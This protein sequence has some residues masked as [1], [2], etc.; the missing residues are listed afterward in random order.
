MNWRILTFVTIVHLLTLMVLGVGWPTMH[1]P[2]RKAKVLRVQTVKLR[3]P[4]PKVSKPKTVAAKPKPKKKAPP[5]KKKPKK[6]AKKTPKKKA[7][8][9]KR[10]PEDMRERKLLEELRE[11]LAKIEKSQK[12][13]KAKPVP[14]SKPRA[15]E[16]QA[17]KYEQELVVRLRLMLRLPEYGD[18]KVRLTLQ[19][20][21]SIAKVE[22]LKTKSQKNE[23]YVAQTLPGMRFPSFGKNYRNEKQHSFILTLTGM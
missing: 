19:R 17:S 13:Y 4:P 16:P 11:S 20:D 7:V 3:P 22:V 8:K 15:A 6:V 9:K 10:D 21:G 5:K 12:N 23:K 2:E 1:T 14:Q 18:V